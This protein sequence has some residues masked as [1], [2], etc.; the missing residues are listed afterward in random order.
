MIIQNVIIHAGSRKWAQ[1]FFILFCLLLLVS[2]RAQ[3]QL[4]KTCTFKLT[5]KTSETLWL[6]GYSNPKVPDAI[7]IKSGLP[8]VWY[9]GSEH[10]LVYEANLPLLYQDFLTTGEIRMLNY[11]YEDLEGNNYP[12][13]F[14][15]RA[16]HDNGLISISK[17]SCMIYDPGRSYETDPVDPCKG[18]N[19][20]GDPLFCI[21]TPLD[22]SITYG[23]AAGIIYLRYDK[24]KTSGSSSSFHSTK[25]AIQIRYNADPSQCLVTQNDYESGVQLKLAKCD[26]TPDS[27]KTLYIGN[28][29]NLL[30]TDAKK[31]QALGANKISSGVPLINTRSKASYWQFL[32]NGVIKIKD[33]SYAISRNLS[34]PNGHKKGIVLD[35]YK[36]DADI[37]LR[38]RIAYKGYKVAGC[39]DNPPTA[40]LFANKSKGG[41][42]ITFTNLAVPDLDDYKWDNK[43]NSIE[44][45]SGT[46]QFFEKP[47]YKGKQIYVAGPNVIKKTSS[48]Y[49]T[50][51][52]NGFGHPNSISSLRPVSC[53]SKPLGTPQNK[54]RFGK[55]YYRGTN[56]YQK[57]TGSSY[58][59]FYYDPAS[60]LI[61]AM[62]KA[63]PTS[64]PGKCLEA[65]GANI[66]VV[67]PLKNCDANNKLQQWSYD[68]EGGGIQAKEI[69][70]GYLTVDGNGL[71]IKSQHWTPWEITWNPTI[72]QKQTF[73]NNLQS[74]QTTSKNPSKGDLIV[75]A[76][77]FSSNEF[78]KDV[79]YYDKLSKTI[80]LASDPSQCIQKKSSDSNG[81]AIHLWNYNPKFN[82]KMQWVLEKGMIKLK[83]NTKKCLTNKDGKAVL[84]DCGGVTTRQQEWDDYLLPSDH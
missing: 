70:N 6:E 49:S 30:W 15:A 26:E 53:E 63:D 78:T 41:H 69:T 25:T 43:T 51:T 79:W 31:T 54:V 13:K 73:I 12:I 81:T 60:G 2:L 4:K 58:R 39:S 45:L 40:T 84:W 34:L 19:E 71:R 20:N 38:W 9:N 28:T 72:W 76:R 59:D 74:L 17:S 1:Q 77:H 36:G 27:L 23:G 46:W 83:A 52:F 68:I 48:G 21:G 32:S 24:N 22:V 44:V 37:H 35:H 14:S 10:T 33:E 5:N 57:V 8:S 11:S 16:L 47:N 50:N 61:H 29:L 66:N 7:E 65:K 75:V 62:D 55:L 80:R 64:Q 67:V 3:A 42:N 82:A 56:N 18:G